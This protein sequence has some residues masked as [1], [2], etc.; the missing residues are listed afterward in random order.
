MEDA[1]EVSTPADNHTHLSS[2]GKERTIHEVPYREAVGSLIF[3]A[4][5]TR[6]DIAFS[7]GVVSR[8]LDKYGYPH[9][10]AVKRI[11]RYLKK[12]MDCGILYERSQ[13]SETVQGFSDSDF[14]SDVDTRKSTTGYVFMLSNGPVTWNSQRQLTVSLSTEAEYIAASSAT[15]ETVWIRQ[16]LREVQEAVNKPT[17]IFVDNQSEIRL[18]RNPEFH[19][20]TKHVNVQY[21]YIREKFINGDIDALYVPSEQQLADTLTKPI[22]CSQFEKLRFNSDED[23]DLL[24]FP[25]MEY[26]TS[27]TRRYRIY[28]YIEIIDLWTEQEFKEHLRLPRH[29][30]LHLIDEFEQSEHF[31][32]HAF[33]TKPISGKI[34]ILLFLWFM[35]NTEPLRTM[36]D[37]FDIFI[38]SVYRILRRVENSL[39]TK[40]ETA[41]RWPQDNYIAVCEGFRAKRGINSIIGAIDATAIR[42][43]KPSINEKDYCNRKKYFS[44][45]LQGVVNASMR[46]TNI[47]CGEPGSLH[48][49]RVLRR[50]PLYQTTVQNKEILFL[51][52]TFIIGD[53]AY[54]SLSW[55][56]LPFRDNGHLTPQQKEFNFLHSSTCMVVKCAFGYL[57][58]RFRRIK[59][60]NEYRQISFITNT[61]VCACILHN[62]CIDE[63]D[64]YDFPEYGDNDPVNV[65]NNKQNENIDWGIQVDRRMQLFRELFPN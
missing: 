12:T 26:L 11:M 8:F 57:K 31:P 50:P 18:I 17:S 5:V 53:S 28:E 65:N 1:N 52:D 62:Y 38:S 42:I 55:L 3:A 7:V 2:T 29:L 25:L 13:G 37:R 21:H 44:I 59:F 6:P 36:S 54:A 61:I 56:V 10:N 34:N 43:E 45:T 15:K 60:F 22:A 14:A 4:I 49:A 39:L 41:I 30:V 27:G 48:D 20:R 47:Y 16:L 23:V 40:L 63:N 33:G 24:Y 51:E 35:S 32:K 9:W 58:G 64:A 46:F 19:K